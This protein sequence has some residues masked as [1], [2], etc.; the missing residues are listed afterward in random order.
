MA[1]EPARLLQV[2]DELIAK[3]KTAVDLLHTGRFAARV[4]DAWRRLIT[5]LAQFL[6]FAHSSAARAPESH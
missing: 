4:P 6:T 3:A 2:V 5:R 1:A